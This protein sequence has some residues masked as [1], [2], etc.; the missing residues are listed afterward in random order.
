[1]LIMGGWV[2]ASIYSVRVEILLPTS[3]QEELHAKM[4]IANGN[5]ENSATAMKFRYGDVTLLLQRNSITNPI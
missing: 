2:V 1:M 3:S 4:V 5:T